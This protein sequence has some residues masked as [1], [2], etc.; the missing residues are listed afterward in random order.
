MKHS[1]YIAY[2]RDVATRQPDLLHTEQSKHFFRVIYSEWPSPTLQLD[3]YLAAKKGELHFPFLL[4]ETWR[5]KLRATSSEHLEYVYTG[6]FFVGDLLVQRKDFDGLEVLF[7][8]TDR[9]AQDIVSYML[10]EFEDHLNARGTG[11]KR[12]LIENSIDDEKIGP[13]GNNYYGTRVS[14]Q[15]TQNVSRSAA[16]TTA[17]WLPV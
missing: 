5:R 16:H 7:D 4:C 6:S 9:I 13:F 10:Q 3:E 15:Y 17:N 11:A 2:F 8:K 14:F 1:D 12:Y